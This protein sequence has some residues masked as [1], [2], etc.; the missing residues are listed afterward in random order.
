MISADGFACA[1]PTCGS[2]DL[3]KKGIRKN[4]SGDKQRY[5]CNE[6]GWSGTGIEYADQGVIDESIKLAK[7]A[8]KYQDIN[9][10]ERKA[11]RES[12]RIL[13]MHE[14]LNTKLI[15]GIS[16]HKFKSPK[17][18]KPVTVGSVGCVHFSD[19]HINELINLPFNKYDVRIC[20]QRIQKYITKCNEHFKA[21][22]CMRVV[23]FFGGD[24]LN[25]DRRLDEITAQ[26]TNRTQAMILA[27]EIFQ[28]AIRD[29]RKLWSIDIVWVCGNEGRVN[30]EIGF[31]EVV[32]SDNYDHAIPM[33][34]MHLFNGVE[35]VNFHIP[36]NPMEV[37][38]NVNGKN[39]L[40]LHGHGGGKGGPEDKAKGI[41][42]KYAERG[43]CID[44]VIWGHIHS[45]IINEL[46]ARS[47]SP[48]GA[49]AF[50]DGALG[51]AGKA[52]LNCYVVTEIGEISGMVIPLQEYSEYEGYDIDESL[53]AYNTKSLSK[54]RK[55][56]RIL[57]IVV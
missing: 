34:L 19:I 56:T 38:V 27:V 29:L 1:C 53:A 10:V 16:K 30:Q 52:S 33:I 47:G 21:N 13:N 3:H 40:L 48:A 51:L 36:E 43:I 35:G 12:A 45:A 46:Y 6:C 32:A 24:L 8:Q 57:E 20:S 2:T 5:M 7:K 22:I 4:A 31:N 9:R 25:S 55:P 39:I 14:T 49:N 26:A 41:R 28:Q 50:S 11:F 17:K 23:I 18:L 15:D 42:G 44:F 54:T 37:V